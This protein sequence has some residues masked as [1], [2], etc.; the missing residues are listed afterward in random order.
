MTHRAMWFYVKGGRQIG[1]GSRAGLIAACR[2]GE[3]DTATLL[4][5]RAQLAWVPAGST[6]FAR[7]VVRL[8][9]GHANG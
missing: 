2:A 7:H 1:A 3:I 6:E 5:D 9:D 8:S 4:W